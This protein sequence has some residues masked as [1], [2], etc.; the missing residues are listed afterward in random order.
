MGNKQKNYLTLHH[1]V[2]QSNFLTQTKIF[3]EMAWCD[4]FNTA[5]VF[6]KYVIYFE[7]SWHLRNLLSF[8]PSVKSKTIVTATAYQHFTER[9]LS[10]E[11]W[12]V[13]YPP[14]QFQCLLN[15]PCFVKFN[16]I[17]RIEN[18]QNTIIF[19]CPKSNITIFSSN[20]H[21]FEDDI[22]NNN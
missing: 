14:F 19:G 21:L 7:N 5:T 22:F 1:F 8:F 2:R 9:S 15:T 11:F 3:R 4:Q 18:D 13:N 16:R 20:C 10:E 6:N 17:Y 12:N